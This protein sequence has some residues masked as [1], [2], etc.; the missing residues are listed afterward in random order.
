MRPSLLPWIILASAG[1]VTTPL[2]SQEP[3]LLRNL[4][5]VEVLVDWVHVPMTEPMAESLRSRVIT[6]LRK[7][8]MLVLDT[9][10]PVTMGSFLSAPTYGFDKPTFLVSL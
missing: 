10:S 3:S 1:L 8:G 4:P 2:L 5:A 9:K 7:A 6:E